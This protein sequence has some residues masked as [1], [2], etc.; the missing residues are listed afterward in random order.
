MIG[1]LAAM[2]IAYLIGKKL[3]DVSAYKEPKEKNKN[4]YK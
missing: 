4:R 2:A 1:S 3:E